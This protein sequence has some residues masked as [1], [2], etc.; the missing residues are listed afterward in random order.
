MDRR[1][2]GRRPA[3]AWDSE[4][5][6]V[7][8][9][10]VVALTA[11]V[12]SYFVPARTWRWAMF[13]FAAQ[14]IVMVL[15]DPSSHQPASARPHHVSHLWRD[16]PHSGSHWRV[17][18][19]ETVAMTLDEA[20]T[21]VDYHYWARDR[22]LEAVDALTPEQYTKDL[23]NSFKSVR[24]TVVHTYG[25]ERNWYLRWVGN[26]PTGFPDPSA[27]PD[28]ATIRAAWKSQEQEVRLFV[29]CSASRICI[30]H[31]VPHL[32]RPGDGVGVRSH[33]AARRQP[34]DVSSRP[35]DDHAET[36][37]CARSEAAGSDSLLPGTR[38]QG[39]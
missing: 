15:Q 7:M 8:A 27:F 34:R 4:L 26:S 23:G 37:R 22:M 12:V 31:Q 35:G 5:Y 3:E 1:R 38:D 32:R 16:V 10:P 29:L 20:I 25:G 30:A 17:C 13:P 28:V 9:L 39:R 18:L 14:A 36:T 24:D 33:A 6:F 19:Q 2:D 11:G 21:L